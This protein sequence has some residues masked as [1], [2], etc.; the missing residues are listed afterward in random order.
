MNLKSGQKHRG[1][2]KLMTNTNPV[3][4]HQVKH[5]LFKK[6]KIVCSSPYNTYLEYIHAFDKVFYSIVVVIV[7]TRTSG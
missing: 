7:Y 3:K 2:G 5:I 4:S 6:W 1:L